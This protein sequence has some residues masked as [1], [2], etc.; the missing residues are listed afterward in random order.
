MS[1]QNSVLALEQTALPVGLYRILINKPETAQMAHMG[2]L[3]HFDQFE[4]C[5]N[6]RISASKNMAHNFAEQFQI[7]VLVNLLRSLETLGK[8]GKIDLA[9]SCY[10]SCSC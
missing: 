5:E 8:L 7:E 4:N 6:L 2:F 10:E 3:K 9:M 1:R